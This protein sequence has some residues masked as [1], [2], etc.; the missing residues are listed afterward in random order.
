M[1]KKPTIQELWQDLEDLAAGHEISLTIQGIWD[2]L[3]GTLKVDEH[4]VAECFEEETI[5]EA[6]WSLLLEE[7]RNRIQ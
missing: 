1:Y 5:Y 4:L 6:L 3:R 7:K 2:Q